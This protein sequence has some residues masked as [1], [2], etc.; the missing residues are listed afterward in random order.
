MRI[1]LNEPELFKKLIEQTFNKQIELIPKGITIDSRLH[2]SGDV[3]IPISGEKFNGYDF[4]SEICKNNP[5][6]IISEKDIEIESP[7]LKVKNNREF[8]REIVSIWRKKFW[9]E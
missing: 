8:I 6:L 3:F 2:K 7:L 4:I 1:D 5:S 9:C